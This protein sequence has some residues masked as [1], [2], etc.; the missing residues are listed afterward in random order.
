MK[1]LLLTQVLPYPPDS[2]PKIK[3][4]NVIKYLARQHEVTLVSFIRGDQSTDIQSLQPYCSAIH[5]I[6]MKRSPKR[7]G[8]ALVRSLASSQPWMMLRDDVAEMRNLVDRLSASVRFDV[9]HA[10]QLNMAQYALRVP[11]VCKVLD[12]HN[13]LWLLYKRLWQTMKNG[14]QKWLLGRDWRLLKRYEARMCQNFDQVM[15]VSEEDRSALVEAVSGLPSGSHLPNITVI[16]IAVDTDQQKPIQRNPGAN[17][18]LY[19]GTMYWPPNI[20][21]VFWFIRQVLPLIR[22]QWPGLIFDVVGARPPQELLKLSGDDSGICV[23]GYVKDTAPYLAQAGA[24]VIPLR[25]GGGMRV[26]ILEALAYGLPMV[27][28][29]LGCEGIALQDGRDILI[30]DTPHEF[31]QATLR[32][33]KDRSLADQLG[34]NGRELVVSTYDYRIACRPLDK[35]Y[36]SS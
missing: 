6:Q 11:G 10:D 14:P 27:S 30:A 7:D 31:A 18:I 23:T 29:S 24:M 5:T 26:K 20:D 28:T 32:L 15:A 1:I 34:R 21:G 4:L 35:V 19:M 9:V 16:P 3:T 22:E 25:A 12:T 2:G 17:H 13:A 36:T 33:L 8:W